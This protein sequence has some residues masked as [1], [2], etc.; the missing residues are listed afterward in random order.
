LVA[1]TLRSR[2]DDPLIATQTLPTPGPFNAMTSEKSKI[3]FI[4]QNM[5]GQFWRLAL[6]LG[7]SAEFDV[8]F[9]TR[10]EDRS[11]P[12]VTRLNYKLSREPD[13]TI[14][15][16][17]RQLEEAVLHGQAVA[18]LCLDYRREHGPPDV[19]IGHPGWGELLYIKDVF[20]ESRLIT[21]AEFFDRQDGCGVDTT[22]LNSRAYNRTAMA[23]VLL[24]MSATDTAWS[25]LAWQRS[26]FPSEYHDRIELIYD[27]TATEIFKPDPH[28][29]FVLEDGRTLKAG[30]EVITFVARG[31]EPMRGFDELARALP[32]ILARRPD[33]RVL[34]VGEDKSYY[35]RQPDSGSW[36]KTFLPDL[37]DASERV[38]FAGRLSYPDYVKAL[39]VSSLHLYVSEPFVLSWSFM[40]AMSTGALVL[41][42][43]TGAV[44][45]VLQDGINGLFLAGDL[46]TAI[47]AAL[48][49]QDAP[50]LRTNARTTVCD[51]YS[52][53]HCLPLHIASIRRLLTKH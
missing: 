33:A 51:N 26:T 52:I 42:K 22:T 27:G 35:A 8:S 14:H 17:L 36:I 1:R 11:L 28:A 48:I 20:P 23:H 9:M 15:P 32:E 41:A 10:R 16:Y 24:S 53:D 18:R 5:P 30:E 2:V 3:L 19:I 47:N 46:P 21:Y 50:T 6:H 25:P 43:E 29:V 38:I 13:K 40:E 39:Q 31:L 12:G 4:H 45:D 44:R 37:G 49:R 7:R 34:I